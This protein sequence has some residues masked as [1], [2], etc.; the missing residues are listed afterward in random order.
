VN[1]RLQVAAHDLIVQLLGIDIQ[2]SSRAGDERFNLRTRVHGTE[3]QRIVG[4]RVRAV[5]PVGGEYG[6]SFARHGRIRV[7]DGELAVW[8]CSHE[9][10]RWWKQHLHRIVVELAT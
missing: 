7:D 2:A 4:A 8:T 3:H 6:F 1:R 5:R 10:L 9:C